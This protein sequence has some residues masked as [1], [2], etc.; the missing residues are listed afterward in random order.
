[1]LVKRRSPKPKSAD[2]HRDGRP[3]Y[4]KEVSTMD[5]KQKALIEILKMKTYLVKKLSSHTFRVETQEVLDKINE[6]IDN[7]NKL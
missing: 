7:V 3:V 2:R 6:L 1:M 5:D 4:N